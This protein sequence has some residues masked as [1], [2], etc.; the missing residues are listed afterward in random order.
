M[1][2]HPVTPGSVVPL[3]ELLGDLLLETAQPAVA[4]VEYERSLTGAPNRFRTLYGAAKAADAAGERDKA[5]AYFGQLA[6][7]ASKADAP[8]P[9]LAEATGYLAH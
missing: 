2:K 4:L 8:L 6:R 5:K 3:R 7:L 1:E 9:E